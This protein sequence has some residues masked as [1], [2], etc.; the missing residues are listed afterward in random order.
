MRRIATQEAPAAVGPYEQGVVTEGKLLFTAGQVA[1]IPNGGLVK[2]SIED[3]THQV[4]SNLRAI[5]DAAG[6]R[7]ANVVQTTI[8]ITDPGSY[9]AVNQVYK[10]Y[11]ENN[12]YPAREC[13][14]VPFLPLLD[15]RVEISM[16]AELPEL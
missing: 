5:L 14:G 9:Q 16:V 2:S 10:E 15:A 1:L 11:F 7:F 6:C 8:Y 13:V 3:E 4:M 12:E